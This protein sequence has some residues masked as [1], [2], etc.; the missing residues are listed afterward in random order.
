MS[1]PER[2]PYRVRLVTT[3]TVIVEHDGMRTTH[4]ERTREQVRTVRASSPAH[5]RRLAQRGRP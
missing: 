3:H 1:A 2:K 4:S 5:A